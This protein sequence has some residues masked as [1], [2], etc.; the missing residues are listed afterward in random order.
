MKDRRKDLNKFKHGSI[1]QIGWFNPVDSV[2]PYEIY[3]A[4]TD[5]D[6]ER[7]R[8]K[9]MMNPGGAGQSLTPSLSPRVP[10][11]PPCRPQFEP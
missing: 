8:P 10:Y 1:H 7:E 11:A 3:E 2:K 9:M 6:L 5:T 4:N